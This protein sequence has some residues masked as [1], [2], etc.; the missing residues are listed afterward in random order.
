MVAK[1]GTFY[2]LEHDHF[3][4]PIGVLPGDFIE[5]GHVDNLTLFS[6][7]PLEMRVLFVEFADG[8]TWGDRQ[9]GE[10]L[11]QRRR[12]CGAFLTTLQDAY[13]TGGYSAV[14]S[15]LV[16][17]SK[18]AGSLARGLAAGLLITEQQPAGEEGVLAHIEMRAKAAQN[19][20]AIA[21]Y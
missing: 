13:Q 1:V 20:A 16:N 9:A 11:L 19:H 6:K 2:T 10:D 5:M 8:S 14:H 3:Y 18:T 12:A 17:E 15:R 7:F 21:E 4:K